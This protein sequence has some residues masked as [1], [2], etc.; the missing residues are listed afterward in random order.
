[1]IAL[2]IGRIFLKYFLYKVFTRHAEIDLAN[3]LG[4][5][6]SSLNLNRLSEVVS[7]FVD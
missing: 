6:N 4:F 1:M 5:Y 3:V 2:V 7:M